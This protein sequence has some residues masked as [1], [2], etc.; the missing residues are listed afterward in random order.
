LSRRTAVAVITGPVAG[1]KTRLAFGVAAAAREAG[2]QIAGFAQPGEW[3]G[4]RKVRYRIVD[5]A[6]GASAPLALRVAAGEGA[7]GTSF[8]FDPAGLKLAEAALLRAG[9]GVF[10]L[11]DELGPLEAAGAGHRAGV[12]RALAAPELRGVVLVIRRGLVETLVA[13][14][15]VV[16]VLVLDV[17]GRHADPARAILSALGVT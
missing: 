17:D 11:A 4:G 14:L 12:A 6:T 13:S 7:G 8:R 10:L 1:G 3:E 16:P 9:P 2:L 15:D 5:L